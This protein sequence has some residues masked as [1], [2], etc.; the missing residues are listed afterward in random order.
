MINC[1]W[2]GEALLKKIRIYKDKRLFRHPAV[3]F[4]GGGR[5]FN[6]AKYVP[7]NRNLSK[8]PLFG[9]EM[10]KNQEQGIERWFHN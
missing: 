5:F 4:N 10:R 3:V 1:S 9:Y 7:A 6:G 8:I 2:T